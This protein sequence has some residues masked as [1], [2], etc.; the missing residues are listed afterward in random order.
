[1][2]IFVSVI[3]TAIVAS[4]DAKTKDSSHSYHH[5]QIIFKQGI[6]TII[7][8]V[9]VTGNASVNNIVIPIATVTTTVN[10]IY[11]NIFSPVQLPGW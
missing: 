4:T 11:A 9:S 5:F 6:F 10:V 3:V 1:M 8:T 2:F 7:V